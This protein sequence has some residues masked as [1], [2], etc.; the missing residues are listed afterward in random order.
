MKSSYRYEATS[1]E[2]FVQQ[3]AC[4]YLRH[5]YWFY[6]MGRIPADKDPGAIDAKLPKAQRLGFLAAFRPIDLFGAQSFA[7][8]VCH[9]KPGR[10]RGH[11]GRGSRRIRRWIAL[12]VGSLR[13][14]ARVIR[15]GRP[16]VGSAVLRPE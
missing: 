16:G 14:G 7:N 9:G 3:V 5:G 13:R 2:G 12:G 4:A 11:D 6:V 10:G 15:K 1:V 8:A